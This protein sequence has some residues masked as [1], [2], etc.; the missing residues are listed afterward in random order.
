MA[1]TMVSHY[2]VESRRAI[3]IVVDFVARRAIAIVVDVIV[4]HV[5]VVVIVVSRRTVAI[6]CVCVLTCLP[7]REGR[8][9]Y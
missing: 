3:A 1:H 2:V 5:I 8:F 6:V 4:R 7:A 9:Q